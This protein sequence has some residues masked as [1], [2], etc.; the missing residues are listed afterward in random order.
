MLKYKIRERNKRAGLSKDR[1]GAASAACLVGSVVGGHGDGGCG[2]RSGG[3]GGGRIAVLHGGRSIADGGRSKGGGG[4]IGDGGGDHRADGNTPVNKPEEDGDNEENGPG[5]GGETE[6]VAIVTAA[7]VLVDGHPD[8]HGNETR[9]PANGGKDDDRPLETPVV[10]EDED[11][12]DDPGEEGGD[13]GNDG[14]GTN[15]V[16]PVPKIAVLGNI[17][18]VVEVVDVR[19]IRFRTTSAETPETKVDGLTGGGGDGRTAADA[20]VLGPLRGGAT[21][22]EE[23]EGHQSKEGENDRDDEVARAGDGGGAASTIALTAAA[24]AATATTKATTIAATATTAVATAV[25]ATTAANAALATITAALAATSAATSLV[26]A[27]LVNGRSRRHRSS[28]IESRRRLDNGGLLING[29]GR[30]T[31]CRGRGRVPLISV[32]PILGRNCTSNTTN[33]GG[34]GRVASVGSGAVAERGS[35]RIV[36]H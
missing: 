12:A 26:V 16:Q 17:V 4:G 9:D 36:A 5:G 29:T 25:A 8:G 35:R 10:A 21:D 13:Q 15:G 22:N 6:R 34:L 2:H 14:E 33:H 31:E 23:D 19:A 28:T 7:E 27:G 3:H 24:V 32:E 30:G 11:D 20:V 1:P 18:G